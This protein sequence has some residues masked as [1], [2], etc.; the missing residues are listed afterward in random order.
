MVVEHFLDTL[1][2]QLYAMAG[3]N[4]LGSGDHSMCVDRR[5]TCE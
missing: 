5:F 1:Q 3:A 4:H 2:I